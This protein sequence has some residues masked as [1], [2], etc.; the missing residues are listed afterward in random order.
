MW[1]SIATLVVAV[2]VPLSIPIAIGF[3]AM[4]IHERNHARN[5]DEITKKLKANNDRLHALNDHINV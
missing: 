3:V 2:W 5:L 4:V 1:E